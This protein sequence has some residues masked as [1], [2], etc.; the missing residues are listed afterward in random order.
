[1]AAQVLRK[2][3]DHGKVVYLLLTATETL[4]VLQETLFV[5]GD[6]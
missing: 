1:M 2:Q 4:T 3:R 6:I 5:E